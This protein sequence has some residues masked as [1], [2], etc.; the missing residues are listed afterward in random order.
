M[1]KTFTLIE[2][3]VV[4]AI[5]AILASMLLPALSKAREKARAISCVNNMK[6]LILTFLMYTD[7]NDSYSMTAQMNCKAFGGFGSGTVSW[8]GHMF[9]DW[10]V[11]AKVGDCPSNRFQQIGSYFKEKNGVVRRDQT[12]DEMH[13]YGLNYSTFGYIATPKSLNNLAS[14]HFCS[15]SNMGPVKLSVLDQYHTSNTAVV[16]TD[17]ASANSVGGDYG[18]IGGGSGIVV[19]CAWAYPGFPQSG[20]YYGYYPMYALHAGRINCAF[21]DGH[22]EG[23]APKQ[24]IGGYGG[25]NNLRKYWQPQY[26]NHDDDAPWN[27]RGL[28][29]W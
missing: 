9:N 3:L 11:G 2:L 16:F 14:G 8:F 4:I 28:E 25:T 18:I 15:W 19:G 12:T 10:N 26:Q 20:N 17:T 13:S 21:I 29:L 27:W 5:I 1:K 7:E 24:I 22:A 6:S 23:L